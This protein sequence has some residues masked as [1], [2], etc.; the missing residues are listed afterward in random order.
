M[1]VLHMSH[2]VLLIFQGLIFDFE[3]QVGGP[4]AKGLLYEQSPEQR[5]EQWELPNLLYP[6][7]L[8]FSFTQEDTVC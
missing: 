1:G 3:A 8:L 6:S 7:D 2:L 4:G 5:Q